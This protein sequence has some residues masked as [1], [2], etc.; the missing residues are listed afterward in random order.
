VAACATAALVAS[1]AVAGAAPAAEPIPGVLVDADLA[2]NLESG[3]APV[4]LSWDRHAATRAEVSAHLADAGLRATVFDGLSVAL[5]C[6]SG[7]SDLRALATAPGAVSVWGD[8]TLEPVVAAPTS[9]AAGPRAGGVAQDLGVD[10][11]GVSLA[12]VDTGVDGRQEAFAGRLR[13]NVRVLVSHREFLG[14]GDPPPCQDLNTMELEDSELTS[15]HGTHLAGVAAG[16]GGVAPGAGL[17]GVG[18]SDSVV[19]DTDVRD[20][21][22]LSMFGALAGLNYALTRGL[23][24]A[25]PVKVVLAG[26]VGRDLYSPFHPISLAIRDLHDFGVSVVLPVGNEGSD[27]SDCSSAA[28]CHV[29]SYAVGPFAIGVAATSAADSTALAAFSSRGDAEPRQADGFPVTYEPLLSAPGENVVGPRRLGVTNVATPPGSPHAGGG[30]PTSDQTDPE[31][32]AMS[33]TSV[34]AARVAGA[35]VLMQQAALHATG[36]YL[37]AD[38]VR[39]LL[40]DTAS[41]MAASRTDAGAGLLDIP[42]AVEAA[43][44][45]EPPEKRN[46][47]QCPGIPGGSS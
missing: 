6:T 16:A 24:E 15:G 28:T 33:G 22:R 30:S 4:V 43:R 35:V 44:A 3:P 19:V 17:I 14:P 26:W 34:A 25:G 21:T 45:H 42:A 36:C 37:E 9:T 41:E 32:I 13:S 1:V 20:S 47:F 7:A 12:V 10:G 40:V 23:D 11:S 2:R 18:I 46:R 8:E 5:T 27:S 38:D 31:Q 39:R 29:S